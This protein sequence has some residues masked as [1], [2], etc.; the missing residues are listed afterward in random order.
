ML[1]GVKR[2]DMKNKRILLAAMLG[3]TLLPMW[4]DAGTRIHSCYEELYLEPPQN[5]GTSDALHILI[6]QTMPVSNDMKSS[7]MNLV[8]DWGRDGD[9]VKIARYSAHVRNQYTQLMFDEWVEADP[10]QE[11]LYHLRDQDRDQLVLCLQEQR[12]QFKQLFT[13][14]LSKTLDMTDP[15]LPQTDIFYSLNELADKL[16]LKQDK[17]QESV[18][19]ISDG[20]EH[21][22]NT[23]FHRRP[24]VLRSIKPEKELERISKKGLIPDWHNARIYFYGMGHVKNERFYVRP[25]LIEPLKQFWHAY[26]K[27]GGGQVV[28]LGTPEILVSSIRTP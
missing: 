7:I 17:V 10:D 12:A 16:L 9:H 2:Q 19:I 3:L 21:S 13:E 5:H 6:D 15:K 8:D 26:F 20:M 22:D 28:H 14:A 25:R 27:K 24:S 4:A 23:T 11:Y 1:Q 18:L